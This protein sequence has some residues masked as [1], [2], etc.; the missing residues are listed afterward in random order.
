M[1]DE[2]FC[3][4]WRRNRCNILGFHRNGASTWMEFGPHCW[5]SGL[6]LQRS[7]PGQFSSVTCEWHFKGHG[8][9]GSRYRSRVRVRATTAKDEDVCKLQMG[10]GVCVGVVIGAGI[11]L[12]SSLSLWWD[13]CCPTSLGLQLASGDEKREGAPCRVSLQAH[14]FVSSIGGARQREH[15]NR[16]PR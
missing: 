8:A 10:G 12:A 14:F 13:L 9:T 5:I 2:E 6:T 1:F 7:P 16:S 15:S 4:F 3:S 11:L